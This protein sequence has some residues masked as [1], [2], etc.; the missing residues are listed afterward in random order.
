M[1]SS[2]WSVYSSSKADCTRRDGRLWPLGSVQAGSLFRVV[3]R[4]STPRPHLL[5]RPSQFA[6]A[7]NA[8]RIVPFGQAH[9]SLVPNQVA[10]IVL[11]NRQ[12]QSSIEENL[13]R[14]G[15]QQIRPAHDLGDAHSCIIDNYR[16]LVGRNVIPS[17]HDEVSK[18]L[19]GGQLLQ[20]QM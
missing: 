20:T 18:I 11:W 13:P 4:R 14:R 3:Q 8:Q 17:P 9:S 15:L 6:Q 19:A 2:R 5:R 7:A 12:T 10:V 1:E 16:Q